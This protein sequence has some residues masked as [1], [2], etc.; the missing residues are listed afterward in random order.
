MRALAA[1]LADIER[2]DPS[3]ADR[4]W[5]ALDGYVAELFAG[6]R[7]LAPAIEP[8]LRVL[9]RF[10]R[11]DGDGVGWAIVHALEHIG[12]YEPALVA[13]VRRCPSELG[14]IMLERLINDGVTVV[15]GTELAPLVAA[16]KSGHG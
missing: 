1:V 2:F 12:G 6:K 14:G 15:D 9:E 8:L 11:G 3:T 13:S 10:P 5:L 7:T 4:G 16:T